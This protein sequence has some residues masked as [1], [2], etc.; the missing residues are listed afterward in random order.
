MCLGIPGR[1]TEIHDDAGLPMA[2]VDFGGVRREV[3]LACTPTASVGTYV[4]VHV[5]FAIT[6]VDEAEA[7]RTLEVLRAMAGAVEDELGEPLPGP[8]R[9]R[10]RGAGR[11]CS[12]PR[13]P[14]GRSSCRA[15]AA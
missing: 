9:P 7:R 8:G 14:L 15:D 3:C 12:C 10:G 11:P 2:T 5:G 1:V 13:R 6:E 4:I